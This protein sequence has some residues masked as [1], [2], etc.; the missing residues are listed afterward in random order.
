[1]SENQLEEESSNE[2]SKGRLLY[3]FNYGERTAD[4]DG[5]FSREEILIIPRS[6]IKDSTEYVIKSICKN[7]FRFSSVK[8]IQFS[9]DSE[10]QTIEKEAFKLCR[11][12][13]ITIPSSLINLTEG[14]CVGA[15][16][17]SNVKVSPNNPR[18]RS[19]DDQTVI[20]KSSIENDEF[21]VLVFCSRKA[22]SITIPKFIKHIGPHCFD[23][24]K[25]LQSIEF[26]ENS[27]LQTIETCAFGGT[28]IQSFTL[29]STVTRI[30]RSA[31]SLCLDLNRFEIPHNSL[32]IQLKI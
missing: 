2:I 25:L 27:E 30:C 1:M 22:T 23:E 8:F 15:L 5:F 20:G 4:I 21:D 10:I 12:E 7:A 26:E 13:S 32:L 19:Y 3:K 17:L 31:F 14:W 6:I 11:I 18:Y 29:P 28:Q 16:E 24:C 9:D